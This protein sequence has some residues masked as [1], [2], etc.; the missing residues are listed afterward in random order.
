VYL[1]R[2]QGVAGFEKEMVVKRIVAE[3]ATDPLFVRMFLDEAR[4]VAKLTHANIVQVFEAGVEDGVPYIAM[5]YIRGVSLSLIIARAH[6]A[7][8]AHYG[9][10]ANIVSGIC[11]GLAYAHSALDRDGEPLHVVHRDVRPSNIV[12][13]LEGVAKLLEF[14]MATAKGR[15]SHGETSLRGKLRYL[16]PEQISQ[17]QVDHRADVFGLGVTLFELTTGRNPFGTEEDP[18]VEVLD[19]VLNGVFARPSE[20]VPGYPPEL[21]SIVLS[22]IER[23]VHNRCP[24]ARELRER[25]QHF[26]SRDE[27]SSNR[28][29]LASYLHRLFPDFSTLTRVA[30]PVLPLRKGVNAADPGPGRSFLMSQTR[31]PPTLLPV[32]RNR[33]GALRWVAMAA[34]ALAAGLVVW[35]LKRAAPPLAEVTPSRA[36]TADNREAARAYLDAAESLVNEKRFDPALD[37]VTKAGNLEV[38]DPS[39]NLRRAHLRERIASEV[40]THRTAEPLDQA[41]P[42]ALEATPTGDGNSLDRKPSSATAG[43]GRTRATLRDTS[44]GRRIRGSDSTGGFATAR[45]H[46]STQSRLKERRQAFVADPAPS[47]P[48]AVEEPPA[49]RPALPSPRLP[50]PVPDRSAPNGAPAGPG[51]APALTSPFS[52]PPDLSSASTSPPPAPRPS[53]TPAAPTAQPGETA[54]ASAQGPAA[55]TSPQAPAPSLPRV[56]VT[57]DSERLARVCAQVESSAISLAGVSPEFARGITVPLR[58]QVRPNTPIYP[59]AMYYF[60]VRE[61]A[62]RRDKHTAAANLADAHS[63][64]QIRRLSGQ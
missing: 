36:P 11:D 15:L 57:E 6:K 58:R 47:E 60:V 14:G 56:Y 24:S 38:D 32:P 55:A 13:S 29:A 27:N 8:K 20:I 10:F 34:A 17:G 35:S 19:R 26:L 1:C 25:L 39:L 37:M 5:E 40:A 54:H 50:P 18:D 12:V 7:G 41:Q 59:M 28:R 23:E 2:L 43:T 21:E 42:P 48:V 51:P 46:G 4:V 45:S 63:T 62:Q 53:P 44:M 9:H 52:A 31:L 33:N 49:A 61:A 30:S 16:A 3:H 22:A 64:G